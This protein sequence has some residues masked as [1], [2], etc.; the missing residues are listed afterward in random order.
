[1]GRLRQNL[2][3]FG[4][5]PEIVSPRSWSTTFGTDILGEVRVE[6]CE[7]FRQVR[8]PLTRELMIGFVF[9]GGARAREGSCPPSLLP[10]VA[11]C[12]R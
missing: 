1:M 2:P 7:E 9:A 8:Q 12:S 3:N 5:G 4:G 10:Y 11:E 6:R